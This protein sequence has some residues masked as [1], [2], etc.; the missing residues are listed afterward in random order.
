MEPEC[1]VEICLE[2]C[3]HQPDPS[4]D[5]FDGDRAHLFR[6]RLGIGDKSGG[7]GWE[8]HLERVDAVGVLVIE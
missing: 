7:F 8:Q 6:L 3:G 4:T 5:A 1:L 2:F